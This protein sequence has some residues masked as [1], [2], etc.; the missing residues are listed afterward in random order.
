MKQEFE[1]NEKP[2]PIPIKNV[3]KAF[4]SMQDHYSDIVPLKQKLEEIE[5]IIAQGM[6]FKFC[7]ESGRL[8]RVRYG[9]VEYSQASK[10]GNWQASKLYRSINILRKEMIKHADTL[11]Y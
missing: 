4:K 7:P 1:D 5:E 3:Y 8:F 2:N 6:T 10:L 9:D 11:C